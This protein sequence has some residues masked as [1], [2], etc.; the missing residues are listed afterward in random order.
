MKQSLALTDLETKALRDAFAQS[1]IGEKERSTNDHTYLLYGGYEP[2]SVKLTS[3]L[4]N[5]SGIAWTS[6]SHT[7]VPVQTSA[8]G[9][10]AEMF[11]GYYD[12]TDIH[13]KVIK[14]SG[15]NI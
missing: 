7:G 4:N 11:N 10:G 6:Y 3:I 2:L 9:V 5:K 13:K 8:I 14:I 1:M 12:Q 15:L